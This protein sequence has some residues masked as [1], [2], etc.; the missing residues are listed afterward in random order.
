MHALEFSNQA[1]KFLK[2]LD[3][4]IFDRIIKRLENLRQEPVPSD[5]KFISRDENGE[6]IF[7]YRIGEYRALYKL[8]EKEKVILIS[9][10]DKRPRVYD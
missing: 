6:K 1:K 9:K 7:R 4:H 8:K 2:K 10:I 3:Q 5:A